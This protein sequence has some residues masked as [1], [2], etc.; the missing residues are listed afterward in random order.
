M[1]EK[2]FIARSR[3]LYPLFASLAIDLPTQWH[4]PNWT[5]EEE[6]H[7]RGVHQQSIGVTECKNFVQKGLFDGPQLLS[8]M[9]CQKT[10]EAKALLAHMRYPLYPMVSIFCFFLFFLL[11]HVYIFVPYKSNFMRS[12]LDV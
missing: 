11:E 5:K 3:S 1:I 4:G 7:Y 6:D 10:L 8:E 12:I 9:L 2:D